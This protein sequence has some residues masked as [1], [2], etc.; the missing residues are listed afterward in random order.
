MIHQTF[1]R[2]HLLR[3]V[4][5][6][7]QH[8]TN[9]RN[10]DE[11]SLA[12]Q[13]RGHERRRPTHATASDQSRVRG[14]FVRWSFSSV[15]GGIGATRPLRISTSL[16]HT[17]SPCYTPRLKYLCSSRLRS[18]CHSSSSSSSSHHAAS[19]AKQQPL[20]SI[21]M[22]WKVRSQSTSSVQRRRR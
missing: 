18:C 21:I 19:V 1:V 11:V 9:P 17:Q 20:A 3:S 8:R 5:L 2:R 6:L 10:I 7:Q 13:K 12:V 4:I 16:H 14:H 22:L 15:V